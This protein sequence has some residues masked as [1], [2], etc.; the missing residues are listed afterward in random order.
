MTGSNISQVAPVA[1]IY[2]APDGNANL[3]AWQLPLANTASVP[4]AAQIGMISG[5]PF[6]STTICGAHPSA[7]NLLQQTTGFGILQYAVAPNTCGSGAVTVLINYSD[8]SSTAPTPMPVAQTSFGDLYLSTGQ[9]YGLIGVD[10]ATHQLNLYRTNAGVP[11]FSAPVALQSGVTSVTQRVVTATRTGQI[12]NSVAFSV[13]SYASAPDQLIEV[14]TNGNQATAFTGTVGWTV[15]TTSAFDNTNFYYTASAASGG[16]V[17][18]GVYATPLGG[19]S[20][21]QLVLATLP[22][23]STCEV[24]DSDG[25]SLV[26]K[27]DA[28][29]AGTHTLYR[30]ATTGAN[31]TPTQILQASTLL[32]ASMDYA[33]GY[34][35]VNELPMASPSTTTAVQLRPSGSTPATP[36][37]G[38][39]VNAAFDLY[40]GLD[41]TRSNTNWLIYTPLP[42]DTTYG[43]AQLQLFP[44]GNFAQRTPVTCPSCGSGAYVIPGG[45]TATV[46]QLYSGLGIG[47]LGFASSPYS[48]VLLNSVSAQ[49]QVF[50]P[51]GQSVTPIF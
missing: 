31:Q 43:G 13:V 33:S 11:N 5:V 16:S 2:L 4:V 9:L 50:A 27:V 42:N 1:L 49:M 39:L 18:C 10:P 19:G 17:Q 38:P 24:V 46:V 30:V 40:W 51:S 22:A 8:S 15:S 23:N 12:R 44:V 41:P 14:D 7:R 6:A 20:T 37:G 45:G 34:L 29:A 32:Q 25:T 3:Q 35:F 36:T 47:L 21:V 28:F 26:Y 48:G